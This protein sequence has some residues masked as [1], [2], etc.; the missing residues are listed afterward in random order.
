MAFS[1]ADL[2]ALEKAMAAGVTQVRYGDQTVTY[3]S[4][5]EMQQLRQSIREEL[6]LLTNKGFAHFT[7][8]FSKGLR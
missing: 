2:T 4:L 5:A 6:G 7:P 1:Q 3:R 8:G